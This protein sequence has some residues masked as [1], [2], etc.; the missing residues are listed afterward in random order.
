MT[1]FRINNITLLGLLKN[2]LV[3]PFGTK[4]P[5]LLSDLKGVNWKGGISLTIFKMLFNIQILISLLMYSFSLGL[6]VW[7]PLRMF[8]SLGFLSLLWKLPLLETISL[9]VENYFTKIINSLYNGFFPTRGWFGGRIEKTLITPSSGAEKVNIDE[10]TKA[11][12]S[13]KDLPKM[14]KLTQFQSNLKWTFDNVLTQPLKSNFDLGTISL[15]ILGIGLLLGGFWIYSNHFDWISTSWTYISPILQTIG[16]GLKTVVTNVWN[17]GSSI[18]N[19]VLHPID[20]Y[21][22]FRGLNVAELATGL[23]DGTTSVITSANDNPLLPQGIPAP[24]YSDVVREGINP[25]NLPV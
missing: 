19:F 6:L 5:I 17:A 15:A 22:Y 14:E 10:L 20:H 8:L 3:N 21:N 1:D 4:P 24:S 12:S 11:L 9:F 2:L 13:L 16:K 18:W 25:S 7:T 23:Q